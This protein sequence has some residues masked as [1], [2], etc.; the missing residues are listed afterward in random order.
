MEMAGG[1]ET[2]ARASK[3][4]AKRCV[5][6]RTVDGERSSDPGC[7]AQA[8]VGGN[9]ERWKCRQ[10]KEEAGWRWVL[11]TFDASAVGLPPSFPSC[12]FRDRHHRDVR[13]DALLCSAHVV[14]FGI[15]LRLH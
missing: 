8:R 6:C 5:R 9:R 3:V 1:V 15:P 12:P 11:A 10:C 13:G 7:D 14:E 4:T 2:S